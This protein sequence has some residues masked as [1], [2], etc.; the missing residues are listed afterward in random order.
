MARQVLVV[1]AVV[2]MAAPPRSWEQMAR[3]TLVAVAVAPL[4]AEAALAVLAS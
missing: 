1:L 2:V 3:Q 4:W